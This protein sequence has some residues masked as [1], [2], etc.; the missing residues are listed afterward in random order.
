MPVITARGCFWEA[1]GTRIRESWLDDSP[2][3][4][5]WVGPQTAL[6]AEAKKL[7]H[8]HRKQPDWFQ[9]SLESLNPFLHCRNHLNAKWLGTGHASD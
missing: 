2:M 5:K 7:G 4:E 3:E 1:V 9:Q 8:E 6:I